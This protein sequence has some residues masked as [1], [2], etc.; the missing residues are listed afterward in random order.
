MAARIAH[1]TELAKLRQA[2]EG[3]RE[4]TSELERNAGELALARKQQ[5]QVLDEVSAAVQVMAGTGA[6]SLSSAV[7]LPKLTTWIHRRQ[8]VLKTLG[9]IGRQD[10]EIARA[11]EDENRHH[12]RLAKAM[13]AA[14]VAHDPALNLEDLVQI[15][16]AA[17]ESDREQRG[18][19]RAVRQEVERTQAELERR[20][21]DAGQAGRA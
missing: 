9:D 3:L 13:T 21:R 18:A 7:T 1:V 10:A 17:V 20:R 19:S 6:E 11:R 5:R 12:E 2:R 8:E 14:R 15:A 4:K 16:Q